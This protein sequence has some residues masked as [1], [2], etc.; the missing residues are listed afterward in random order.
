MVEAEMS[1]LLG[2]RCDGCYK[3][4]DIFRKCDW[5]ILAWAWHCEVMVLG[6]ADKVLGAEYG[7]VV[8]L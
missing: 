6:L 4:C 3:W 5:E 8:L 7:I 2:Y 1:G